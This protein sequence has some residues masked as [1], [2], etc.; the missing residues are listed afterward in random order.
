MKQ[1]IILLCL[2]IIIGCLMGC[3]TNSDKTSDDM[4]KE[5]EAREQKT[6]S[7]LKE[8]VTC[9]QDIYEQACKENTLDTLD[10]QQKIVNRLGK[11]GYA[12]LDTDNQIDMVN[13]GQ[14][15][16]F[17]KAAENKK[18][19]EVTI[20]L[21][22]DNGGLVRY[23]L[24]TEEG[25]IH[26]A[27]SSLFLEDSQIK[28]DYYQEYTACTW[29]YTKKGYLFIE[30]YH[31]SGY[32]GEPGQTAIRV[33]PLDKTLRKLN[34]KYVMPVG[35]RCNKLLI[36]NWDEKNYGELDFYDLYEI[37]YKMKYKKDVP[38]EEDWNCA[39]YEVPEKEF[40]EVIKTYLNIDNA[41]LRENTVYHAKTKTYYYRT[42]GLYDCGGPY[43][44]FPEV[45]D[46]ERQE[47]GTVKLT[48]DAVWNV[49][50]SD[51][52]MTSELV[53]RPLKDGGFQYVSNHIIKKSESINPTWYTERLTDEEV[54]E[55]YEVN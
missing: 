13:A 33:K 39:E 48:V 17:C 5:K 10:V 14:A 6:F 4:K 45:I 50:N 34:R 54:D 49:G 21:V 55:F 27:V 24:N 36:T 28:T 11:E 47:D 29:S 42:R 25:E 23:D 19:G 22:M 20:L 3:Q 31:M 53:I 12:A 51:S 32:D 9:Y 16:K 8:I 30:Q 41:T 44:P 18:K 15:E 35:Y 26:V 7:E 1:K 52:A 40:E 46:Y 38:Y 2:F 37:M 43:E